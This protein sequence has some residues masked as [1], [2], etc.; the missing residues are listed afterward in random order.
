MT[1]DIPL[2]FQGIILED[3]LRVRH[4]ADGRKIPVWFSYQPK[5]GQTS[6]PVLNISTTL[7]ILHSEQGK[8]GREI[9]ATPRGMGILFYISSR[10][11]GKATVTVTY[12][13]QPLAR[14]EIL[15][16]PSVI[17]I[18]RRLGMGIL[19]VV[20]LTFV[21]RG[22]ILEADGIPS[23]LPEN[24]MAPSFH[25]GERFFV[26]KPAYKI[27]PPRRGEI[28]VIKS[29][30]P[31]LKNANLLKR[32]V[33]IPGDIVE[34]R[35][36]VLFIN[37]APMD[38]P[39]LSQDSRKAHIN[40][41]PVRVPENRFFVLGDNRPY[42]DDS[43]VWY[44]NDGPDAAFVERKR[45]VGKPFLVFWP[46]HHLRLIFSYRLQAPAQ[47]DYAKNSGS[48]YPAGVQSGG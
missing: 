13:G 26:F 22:W 23:D 1:L 7:G 47:P 27:R 19:S 20:V 11:H 14:M 9:V 46:P 35:N 42:S 18:L 36:D 38:E 10:M 3:G 16:V 12:A 24:S 25:L 34:I 17:S 2:D 15:F 4:E 39:Y 30:D 45:F 21:I 41:P 8:S 29:N 31:E 5:M 28:V 44:Y 37:G 48:S 43:R 6:I 33:G 40:F 32:V